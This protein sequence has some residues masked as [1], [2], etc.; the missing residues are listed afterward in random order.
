MVR[1]AFCGLGQMGSGMVRRLAGAGHEVTAWNRSRERAEALLDAGVRVAD[2]PAAAAEGADVC[3]SMVADD[4]ASR[5]VWLGERGML[6]RMRP[7]TLAVECSTLS[8][9]WALELGREA[10]SR[11]VVPLDCPVTGL[12]EAAARGGLVLLVG[13]SDAALEAARPCLDVLARET[14]HFGPIGAGT[15]YKLIVN[16]LGAVEIAATAEAM[17]TA[18]RAGL[19]P[20]Q[21]ADAL[22]RGAAGSFHV[23]HKARI[24]A[25]GRHAEELAFTTDLRRKDTRYGL[26][27]SHAL[28]VASPLGNLAL[29][30]F[31][32]A[33]ALGFGAANESHV[34][35]AVRDRS[36]GTA[37]TRGRPR[38]TRERQPREARERRPRDTR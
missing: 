33:S 8:H 32:H 2:S 4:E 1:V 30:H 37:P 11:G 23:G 19:D 29:A 20:E 9:D 26:A 15:A 17:E 35:D 3:F 24:M 27:L 28:G 6:A 5:A 13:G 18:R 16:L 36:T 38:D 34:L 25:T 7:G 31:D 14:I 21:V 12:P 10:V 22:A